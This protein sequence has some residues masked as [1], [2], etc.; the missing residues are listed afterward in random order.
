MPSSGPPRPL[1]RRARIRRDSGRELLESLPGRSLSP[2]PFRK[3]AK[4]PILA[5]ALL[6]FAFAVPAWAG[7]PRLLEYAGVTLPPDLALS[8]EHAEQRAE[9]LK[10][11]IKQQKKDAKK[12]VAIARTLKKAEDG[13]LATKDLIE[14][15]ERQRRLGLNESENLGKAK[16]ILKKVGQLPAA[17]ADA[18]KADLDALG[19]RLDERRGEVYVDLGHTYVLKGNLLQA[20]KYMGLALA[21]DPNDPNALALRSAI[22][23]ATS[24][25]RWGR[26]GRR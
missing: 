2:L 11:Q 12:Q 1:R 6:R 24:N 25:D 5:I 18:K 20:N 26:P 10:A 15:G 8:S 19:E 4:G 16:D 23:A 21:T 7:G 14:Q 13:I 3:P 9:I 22:T 17:A